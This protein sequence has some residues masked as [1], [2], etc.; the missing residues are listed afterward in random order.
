M[1]SADGTYYYTLLNRPTD[2]SS[3]HEGKDSSR[4][5]DGGTNTNVASGD[6][7]QTKKDM[8]PWWAVDMGKLVT[9]YSVDITNRN[10]YGIP[11]F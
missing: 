5:V 10:Q 4:A 7:I 6:C 2:Q 8:N 9:V 3:V 11:Y 1:H